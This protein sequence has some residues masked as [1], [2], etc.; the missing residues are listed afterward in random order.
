MSKYELYYQISLAQYQEQHRRSAG[1]DARAMTMIAV[2]ATLAGIGAVILKD[3]SGQSTLSAWTIAVTG[4]VAITFVGAAT[5][6]I[7]GL[8]P[9]SG[10]SAPIRRPWQD[11]SIH[12]STEYAGGRS[13]ASVVSVRGDEL[14]VEGDAQTGTGRNRH[15]AVGVDEDALPGGPP[16]QR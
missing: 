6:A 15:R 10:A 14:P 11:T 9:S 1:F 12:R 8:R 4:L 5:S 2:A 7:S 3:F 16:A 13:A